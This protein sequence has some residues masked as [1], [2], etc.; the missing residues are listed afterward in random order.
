M[1]NLWHDLRYA[2]RQLR[3]NPGFAATAV[4]TLALGIAA[5]STIF[6]WIHSTLFNPIPGVTHTGNMITIQR[7]E[8]SEHAT[9]PLSYDDYLDL[10]NHA[11]TLS[12]L[13][14]YHDDF[15]ALTGAGMPV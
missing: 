6:C 4:I 1:K 2:L 8:R 12:G 5:T 14:G 9:P 13:L 7:G 11:T 3:K 15:M 10:R